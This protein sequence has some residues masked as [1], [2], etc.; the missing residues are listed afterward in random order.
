LRSSAIISV[1]RASPVTVRVRIALFEESRGA[2][3]SG[4]NRKSVTLAAQ[5]LQ[6][7]GLISYQRGKIRV[8]IRSVTARRAHLSLQT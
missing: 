4:A 2:K 5:S 3:P 6:A 8:V 7:A 1:A